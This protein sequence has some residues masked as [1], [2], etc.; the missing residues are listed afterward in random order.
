L[1]A[2]GYT[3]VDEQLD[4]VLP[5]FAAAASDMRSRGVQ[6]VFDAIDTSGNARLCTAIDQAGLNLT[7]KVTTAQSWDQTVAATYSA[8][9]RCRNSLY[10]TS[11]DRNYADTQYPAV[12][13]FRGAMDR[14]FPDRR[15]TLSMWELE[16]WASAQWLTDAIAS[17]GATVTRACVERFMNRPQPYDAH[18][19]LIPTRFDVVAPAATSRSCLNVARWQDSANRGGGGWVTQVPDMN[20]NCF[21]VP[22]VS[23]AP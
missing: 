13:A 14:Y 17:C 9:P 8:A 20:A 10:A 15:D 19:L 12:A 4:F 3:V 7:A 23:Y 5:N 22:V 16:G 21:T 18:G 11:A 1:R 6:V 2:E